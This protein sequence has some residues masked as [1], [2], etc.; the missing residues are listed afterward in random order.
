MILGMAA[1]SMIFFGMMLVLPLSIKHPAA[2]NKGE[3]ISARLR[4]V[5]ERRWL[6]WN[7]DDTSI[8]KVSIANHAR[9]PAP[10]NS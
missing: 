2:A 3:G 5:V 8:G 9:R 6:A 4:S 1:F 10:T 7:A